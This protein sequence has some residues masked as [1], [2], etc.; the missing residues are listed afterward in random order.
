MTNV[1]QCTN[2]SFTTN[3]KVIFTLQSCYNNP[4]LQKF[5]IMSVT[6]VPTVIVIKCQKQEWF[7]CFHIFSIFIIKIVGGPGHLGGSC[8]YRKVYRLTLFQEGQFSSLSLTFFTCKSVF[9]LLTYT[10]TTLPLYQ[11][12]P[13]IIFCS[14]ISISLQNH[15]N[16]KS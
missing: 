3:I 9:K 4:V 12:I 13:F 5:C 10:H 16:H 7:P 2:F 14:Y 8:Q 1:Q 11:Y 6:K 15:S